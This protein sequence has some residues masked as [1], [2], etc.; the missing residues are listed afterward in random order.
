MVGVSHLVIVHVEV[1]ELRENHKLCVQKLGEAVPTEQ[2][3]CR[4]HWDR[5]RHTG[6]TK[7]TA[8]CYDRPDLVRV[9]P[10]LGRRRDG[11]LW[12]Q[13]S[14]CIELTTCCWH[15]GC[16]C[17]ARILLQWSSET[18]WCQ[19]EGGDEKTQPHQPHRRPPLTMVAPPAL[20]VGQFGTLS[21]SR[22]LNVYARI[23]EPCTQGLG[24][25]VVGMARRPREVDIFRA[26]S[27]VKFKFK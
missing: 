2:E 18:H 21:I 5:S 22:H 12:V 6:K 14:S 3:L 24:A 19:H 26:H 1:P 16:R 13:T 23:G 15:D 25:A 9:H 17:N 7:V 8:V 10:A 4:G 11:R 20:A 27:R